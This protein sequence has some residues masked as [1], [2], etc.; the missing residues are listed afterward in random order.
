MKLKRFSPPIGITLLTI[1]SSLNS[2]FNLNDLLGCLMYDLRASELAISNLCPAE[3]IVEIM[4]Y[5]VKISKKAH[6]LKLKRRH[7]KITVLTSNTPMDNPNI[8]ME[9]YI[10][11]KEEKARRHG[12][13]YNWETAKKVKIYNLC[14]NLVDFAYMDLPPRDQRFR[15][16]VLDLDIIGA[17]QF[18][19]VGFGAYWAESARQIPDKGDL[20]AY[21]IGISS[22]RD[23]LGTASSYTS[24][25]DPMLRLCH[26]LIACSIA[27]RSQAPKKGLTVIVRDLY[28]IDTAVVVRLTQLKDISTK[29]VKYRHLMAN[30]MCD[31]SHAGYTDALQ[32]HNLASITQLK[33]LTGAKISD[34][35]FLISKSMNYRF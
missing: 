2:A 29:L 22:A 3:R 33:N 6:I 34:E 21:W 10:R 17:L 5:L 14:T 1:T 30:P 31:C 24:I 25:K 9:E 19:L 35:E 15:E 23:F 26:R 4:E 18:Q 7:L 20:S 13:V 28:V 32:Q 11:L 8:I 16:V 27:G 12:K